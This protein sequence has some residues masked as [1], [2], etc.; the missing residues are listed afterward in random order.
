VVCDRY[1]PYPLEYDLCRANP[2]TYGATNGGV[3]PNENTIGRGGTFYRTPP[4]TNL[5]SNM[6]FD[7][8]PHWSASWG[9][10]YDF[11]AKNFA[12]QIV[13]VQRELH[14]WRAIFGFTKGPNGNFAF[15]FFIS[16]NAQP[17]LKF[18]YDRRSYRQQ[19]VAR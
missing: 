8:T 13:T 12:S 15:T 5:G 10:Q 6:S 4:Q 7:I 2:T 19:G 14:D 18:D 17:D 11:R 16:L 3:D 9:T 1:R